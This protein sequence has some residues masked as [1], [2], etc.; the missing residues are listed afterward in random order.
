MNIGF[1]CGAMDLL[2]AGHVLMLQEARTVCDH[3]TVFIQSNP[4]I[5]RPEKNVPVQNILE[6]QIQVNACRF[7][8]ESFVY[9]TEE[10]VIDVLDS[11][12]WDIR[13]IGEEY[14]DIDFTGKELCKDK[15]YFNKRKHSFSSTELRQRCKDS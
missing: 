13:I 15:C 14:K 11:Y 1:T 2:H 4:N 10:D 5:D 9:Y 8:D 12:P 6:R 7:V 3:L